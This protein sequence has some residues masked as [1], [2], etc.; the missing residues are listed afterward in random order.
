MSR[1]LH[2]PLAG[3]KEERSSPLLASQRVEP[4]VIEEESRVNKSKQFTQQEYSDNHTHPFHFS[5]VANHQM[6]A[7]KEDKKGRKKPRARVSHGGQLSS[8]KVSTS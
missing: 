6:T 3:N 5:T 1:H 2:S 7:L 8:Y 4:E